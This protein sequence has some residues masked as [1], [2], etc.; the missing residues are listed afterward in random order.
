MN[1]AEIIALID[2]NESNFNYLKFTSSIDYSEIIDFINSLNDKKD[3]TKIHH[4]LPSGVECDSYYDKND[5]LI[6]RKGNPGGPAQINYHWFDIIRYNEMGN[7]IG[8]IGLSFPQNTPINQMTYDNKNVTR[9]IAEFIG[10]NK[11]NPKEYQ[12]TGYFPNGKTSTWK[13]QTLGA[14]I[15]P[16]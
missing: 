1:L 11:N 12:A 5:K 13:G 14:F 8:K 4:I 2:N 3:I 10:E 16:K 9:F 6:A 15:K 7:P